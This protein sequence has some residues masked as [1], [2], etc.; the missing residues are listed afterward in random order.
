[1]QDI[2]RKQRATGS[3]AC[4]RAADA[5]RRTNHDTIRS[6]VTRKRIYLGRSM[7]V[8]V[9]LGH[10]TGRLDTL[11]RRF[12]PLI[13]RG[14]LGPPQIN[15]CHVLKLF[16]IDTLT[17]ISPSQRF[18]SLRL[19]S[20]IHTLFAYFCRYKPAVMRHACHS[21]ANSATSAGVASC[22]APSLDAGRP[23]VSAHLPSELQGWS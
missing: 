4:C 6:G 3:A 2:A 11:A 12:L 8:V 10:G 13:D 22:I 21:R 17:N 14:A 18:F 20:I 5:P 19:S 1:M 16:S 9:V 7:V 15:P 23:P